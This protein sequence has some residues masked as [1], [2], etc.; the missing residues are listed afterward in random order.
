MHLFSIS[1]L[2]ISTTL[3]TRAIDT[4][5][6]FSCTSWETWFTSQPNRKWNKE[7]TKHAVFR[8]T[9]SETQ[10]CIECTTP[11]DPPLP[12]SLFSAICA[13]LAAT[14]STTQNYFSSSGRQNRSTF[15]AA[16][17]CNQQQ[18]TQVSRLLSNIP[19]GRPT[20][21]APVIIVI[22]CPRHNSHP[23]FP[24]CCTKK[25]S[26]LGNA[27]KPLKCP[28]LSL[29]LWPSLC[30]WSAAIVP[31]RS[32]SFYSACTNWPSTQQHTT[33]PLSFLLSCAEPE[34]S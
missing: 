8:T 32:A 34:L 25:P 22:M 18:G 23:L 6:H 10:H 7:A 5:V 29:I 24:I 14:A 21:R 27:I 26:L 1:T 12:I 30:E 31:C 28:H 13:P 20:S 9:R 17:L 19:P 33:I 11:L 16:T 15:S 2:P 4:T 3:G